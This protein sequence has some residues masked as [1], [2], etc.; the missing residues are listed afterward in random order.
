MDQIADEFTKHLLLIFQTI[1]CLNM[2][3][4]VQQ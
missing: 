4:I 1:V 2:P 3:S